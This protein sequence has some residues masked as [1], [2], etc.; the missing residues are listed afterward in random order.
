MPSFKD[1]NWSFC[2]MLRT[3]LR[4]DTIFVFLLLLWCNFHSFYDFSGFKIFKKNFFIQN[5]VNFEG[6]CNTPKK[7]HLYDPNPPAEKNRMSKNVSPN[8]LNTGQ[9]TLLYLDNIIFVKLVPCPQW[10]LLYLGVLVKRKVFG[11]W[12]CT[13][14]LTFFFFFACCHFH[15]LCR[16]LCFLNIWA[17]TK[18]NHQTHHLEQV[19]SPSKEKVVTNTKA[20]DGSCEAQKPEPVVLPLLLRL[21]VQVPKTVSSVQAAF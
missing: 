12:K 15:G 18:K 1:K 17:Y 13:E 19:R 4:Y 14:V 11:M 2:K 21:P 7:F 3:M 9:Q 16:F 6:S 20:K 10:L 8:T 5:Q